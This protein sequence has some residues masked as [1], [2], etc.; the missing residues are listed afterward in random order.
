MFTRVKTAAELEAM[1]EGGRMLAITLQYL[2]SRIEPGV[3]TK[4]LADIAAKEI[5]KLG[6]V[7]TTLGYQ[8]FP[9]VICISVNDEVVHGI[10]SEYKVIQGGDIVSLDFVVT[11]RNLVTDAALSVIAGKPGSQ[12]DVQ[13]LR[14]TE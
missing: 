5:R 8:G 7:P 13:L 1:R 9:D 14:K 2:K 10:P 12:A 6:G 11:Y 3:H 4:E